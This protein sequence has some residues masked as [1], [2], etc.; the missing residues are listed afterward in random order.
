MDGN[1]LGNCGYIVTCI[2]QSHGE[3]LQ[4]SLLKYD[5]NV[6]ECWLQADWCVSIQQAFQSFSVNIRLTKCAELHPVSVAFI[7]LR[8]F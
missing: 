3:T 4:S 7:K 8:M 6:T 2:S 1:W 5:W